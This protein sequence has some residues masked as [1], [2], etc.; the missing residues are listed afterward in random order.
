M[1]LETNLLEDTRALVHFVHEHVAMRILCRFC[2]RESTLHKVG[3]HVRMSNIVKIARNDF[4]NFH[5]E[6]A[7]LLYVCAGIVFKTYLQ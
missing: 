4:P 2:A 1:R 5:V 7:S 6:V 3:R